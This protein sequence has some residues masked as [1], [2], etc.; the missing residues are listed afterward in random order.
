MRSAYLRPV[1]TN[2]KGSRG[3]IGTDTDDGNY[4]LEIGSS[5]YASP[6]M[7]ALCVHIDEIFEYLIAKSDESPIARLLLHSLE[8]TRKRLEKG[9]DDESLGSGTAS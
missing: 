3:G 7:V 2:P 4:E 1:G 6:D 9:L 8:E 5:Q